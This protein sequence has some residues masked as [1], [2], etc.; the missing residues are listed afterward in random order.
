M[1]DLTVQ[2]DCSIR[3]SRSVTVLSLVLY[4]ENFCIALNEKLI[5]VQIISYHFRIFPNDFHYINY[6]GIFKLNSMCVLM[7]TVAMY[8]GQCPS[9]A[10]HSGILPVPR[11]ST[12]ANI[13]W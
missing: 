11:R 6:G 2:D 7:P 5:I 12:R 10:Q 9:V 4:L 1:L 8:P 13:W 3:V